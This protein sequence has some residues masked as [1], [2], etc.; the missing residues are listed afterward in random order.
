MKNPYKRK[1]PKS[2]KKTLEF[3]TFSD[4][5]KR[6]PLQQKSYIIFKGGSSKMLTFDD[7]GGRGVKK[8]PKHADVIYEW[9][10]DNI[11]SKKFSL[12]PQKNK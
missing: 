4:L 3:P 11:G 5:R 9:S 8:Y 2:L 12:R 10:L 7:K 1:T 6:I